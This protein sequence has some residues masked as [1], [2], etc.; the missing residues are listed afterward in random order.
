MDFELHHL[1]IDEALE[2][3]KRTDSS[4]YDKKKATIKNYQS[5]IE[6]VPVIHGEKSYLKAT[7][8]HRN[9][10]NTVIFRDSKYTKGNTDAKI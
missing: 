7:R 8:S 10:F 4:T 9:V 5:S 1:T 3:P 2:K 6:E